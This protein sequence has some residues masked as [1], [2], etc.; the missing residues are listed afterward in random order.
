MIGLAGLMLNSMF[1]NSA[2]NTDVFLCRTHGLFV[3]LMLAE[4]EKPAVF[5]DA[6][7]HG[8]TAR[9][10]ANGKLISQTRQEALLPPKH[11]RNI[12]NRYQFR[13]NAW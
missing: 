3:R 11:G 12:T 7:V 9:E 8:R 13:H 5:P 1:R 6:I 2:A 4:I 10:L